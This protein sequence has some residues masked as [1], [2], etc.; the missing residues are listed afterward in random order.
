MPLSSLLSL[1]PDN[2]AGD[3]S[4]AD[5]RSVV[6]SLWGLGGCIR[7]EDYG[8][9]GDGTTN[10]HTAL[11]SA[12]SAAV[13]AGM[14]VEFDPTKIYAINSTL[15]L[16]SL[17]GLRL[18]G[19][20]A[21]IKGGSSPTGDLD[22]RG[23]HFAV[24][25]DEVEISGFRFVS[26]ITGFAYGSS[27]HNTIH[28]LDVERCWIHHN[29]L[30]STV[31]DDIRG[32]MVKGTGSF[33]NVVE[34]NQVID[35]EGIAYSYAGACR[36]IARYNFILRSS[37]N[38]MT[39]NGNVGTFAYGN[40][41]Y[42]NTIIDSD[43]M[44]I[45][46]YG[47]IEN[48]HIYGNHI[49]NT[50]E[51]PISVVGRQYTVEGNTIIDFGTYGIEVSGGAGSFISGNMI[52]QTTTGS[53]Y[54]TG[55]GII[56]NAMG[57]GTALGGGAVVENNL[58]RDVGTGIDMRNHHGQSRVAHNVVIDAEAVGVNMD[59]TN[60][61]TRT[62]VDGNTIIFNTE[63]T[64]ARGVRYGIQIISANGAYEGSS[65]INNHIRYV[66]SGTNA[67]ESGA[68]TEMFVSMGCSNLLI[69]GNTFDTNGYVDGGGN[70]IKVSG[71]G[72]GKTNLRIMNNDFRGG[73]QYTT[74]MFTNT[75]VTDYGNTVA[76]QSHA[77]GFYRAGVGLSSSDIFQ[78]RNSSDTVLAKITSAGGI[79]TSGTSKIGSQLNLADTAG[80]VTWQID[81]DAY[82]GANSFRLMDGSGTNWIRISR[83]GSITPSNAIHFMAGGI[84]NLYVGYS[85]TT[86]TLGFFGTSPIAKPT[87]TGSRGGNAALASL[88][89]A[90]A[91]LGLVVDSTSA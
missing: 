78:W 40:Q 66:M 54:H 33:D 29:I 64:V 53:Y 21:R 51:M 59:G 9:V 49:E 18:H 45:E 15:D 34:Y 6:T 30:E 87:V 10:D 61:A 86:P 82:T 81:P 55:L 52:R 57:T 76:N 5:L 74:S 32:I 48:S 26:P 60:P 85:S 47:N 2:V 68:S 43:R 73:A 71:F 90:L 1:L 72:S 7:P 62:T 46:D 14:P 80:T 56:V 8:A 65:I 11:M 19:N 28:L 31:A 69:S 75:S 35:S 16:T 42:G 37:G 88:I 79:E 70:P 77:I 25:S 83:T 67:A 58:I 91:N 20:L 27:E 17:A 23:W 50:T 41:V 13:A 22:G 84:A 44:G 38:S 39:G 4:A 24:R 12:F 89:T 36:T 3:I 63:L